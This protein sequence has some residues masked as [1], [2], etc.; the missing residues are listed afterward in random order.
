MGS[1]SRMGDIGSLFGMTQDVSSNVRIV[2]RRTLLMLLDRPRRRDRKW[3]VCERPTAATISSVDERLAHLVHDGVQEANI[4]NLL[5]SV[6]PDRGFFQ[7]VWFC[8][9]DKSCGR[10]GITSFVPWRAPCVLHASS[11]D[12][13]VGGASKGLVRAGKKHVHEILL[14]LMPPIKC[15]CSMYARIDDGMQETWVGARWTVENMKRAPQ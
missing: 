8:H 15:R 13:P 3:S 10:I 7:C 9:G 6:D 5:F 2:S 14:N 12:S 11:V 1:D 4:S